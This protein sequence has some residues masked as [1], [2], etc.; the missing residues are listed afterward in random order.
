MSVIYE[1]NLEIDADTGDACVQ[2]GLPRAVRCLPVA[3]VMTLP[4]SCP[5]CHVCAW[6]TRRSARQFF[7]DIVCVCP[8]SASTKHGCGR[9][10]AR[11]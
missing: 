10:S 7:Y 11:S 6:A 9:T 3:T 2:R 1:V 4:E 8:Q 5:G